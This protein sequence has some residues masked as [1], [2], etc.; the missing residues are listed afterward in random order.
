MGAAD[1][2][3]D[4]SSLHEVICGFSTLMDNKWK[5]LRTIV[6]ISW[7]AEEVDLSYTQPEPRHADDIPTSMVLSAAPNGLKILHTGLMEMW[8]HISIL[9]CSLQFVSFL[10]MSET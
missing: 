6:M 1:P 9:V 8:S 7:D 3:P 2:V 10:S 5:P 4:H